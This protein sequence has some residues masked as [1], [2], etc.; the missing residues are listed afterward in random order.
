[1][2]NI[3]LATELAELRRLIISREAS[4]RQHISDELRVIKEAIEAIPARVVDLLKEQN[5]L[6]RAQY[7]T[8]TASDVNRLLEERNAR[9]IETLNAHISSG[10]GDRTMIQSEQI[11]T[12]SSTQ[13]DNNP[14]Y[15]FFTWGG[16]IDRY[17]PQDFEF[18]RCPVKEMWHLWY[19]GD[20]SRGIHPL[21]R[22]SLDSHHDDLRTKDEKSNLHR[23][24][25]VME[26]LEGCAKQEGLLREGE[27]I[28]CMSPEESERLYDTAYS[29]LIDELYT[30]G[31]HRPESVK[32]ATIAEKI[33]AKR[34]RDNPNEV[35]KRRRKSM[36]AN[37][38]ESTEDAS[39]DR[40]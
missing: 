23:A 24:R 32:Y 14:S 1:M 31:A 9:I 10:V 16:K 36:P 29:R 4:I 27:A 6:Q 2:N 39:V 13:I 15:Q 35:R 21:Y 30:N 22:L 20:P 12:Q 26:A 11:T 3:E 25:V 33:Y 37:T 19:Y 38:S 34:R 7:S 8:L 5:F 40:S 17:V 18:P 28:S